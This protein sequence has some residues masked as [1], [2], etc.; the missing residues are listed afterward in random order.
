MKTQ[1]PSPYLLGLLPLIALAVVSQLYVL[2][3][4]TALLAGSLGVSEG[5]ASGLST[6]F[7]IGYASGMLVWGVLSDRYGRRRVLML[8]MSCLL[9]LT[10]LQTW[11][12]SWQSLLVLRGA[13][14]FFAATFAPVIMVWLAENVAL[15][16]RLSVIAY[17]SC[18]F[19]LAGVLG[20]SMGA[21]LIID[22]LK[23]L[24]WVFAGCYAL[25]LVVIGR[26]PAPLM[27]PK[28]PPRISDLIKSLPTLLVHPK[29]RALYLTSLLL[30]WTFV[31]IYVWL[32][33]HRDTGLSQMGLSIGLVRSIALPAMLLT[34]NSVWL[35]RRIGAERVLIGSIV[36]MMLSLPFQY[37]SVQMLWPSGLLLG[38]FVYVA[39]LAYCLPCLIAT[40]GQ[41]AQSI[42]TER[43]SNVQG[44]A[45][46]MYAFLLFIGTSLGAY[47]PNVWPIEWVFG[48]LMLGLLAAAVLLYRGSGCQSQ[49]H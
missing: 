9:W 23:T 43:L 5:Q 16:Q 26:L 42:Q 19:L 24:M 37:V 11:V 13:Q 4:V 31:V 45:V 1:L 44:S 33:Q 40:V 41:Q 29:L 30:L 27:R 36:V 39:A 25:A 38:H 49:G 8:G 46:S 3:P 48:V 12:E 21:W 18:A 10:L 32:T 22:D 2:L 35:I 6:I 7:S 34:L 20:Q 47:L 17:L 14:G 28:E 15:P